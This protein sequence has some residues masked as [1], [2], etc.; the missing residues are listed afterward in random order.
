MSQNTSLTHGSN[1]GKVYYKNNIFYNAAS[2]QYNG[3]AYISYDN[4]LFYGANAAAP[5]DPH[6]VVADPL[7]VNPGGAANRA[8]ADA[9]KL[10]PGSPAIDSGMSINGNGGKD[11][12]GNPLYNGAPDI[13]AIEDQVT[14]PQPVTI[15]SDD[16]EDNDFSNWT[17][18][19]G[20]WSLV[21][22]GSLALSQNTASGEALAFTGDTSWSDY[23][24]S[25][26]VKLLAVTG[27]AGL[28][29]SYVDNSNYYALRLNDSG[30]KVELYK[31]SG[32]TMTLA[33]STS[34]AVTPGR[35]A[36]MKVTVSGNTITGFVDGVQLLQWTDTSALPAG[37]IGIRMHTST[38]RID[39]VKVI[40]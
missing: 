29:F 15:F 35:W 19:G 28:V 16:F 20:S 27:N 7:F 22:D 10:Q 36:E 6:K 2:S 25:A 14:V 8:T 18:S 3:S 37:K 24:Y 4:N 40:Q 32:G 26:R 12:F 30:D 39:D 17:V 13:G 33:S 5:N 31:K 11:F 21:T 9:Y 34:Y 38:A 23:T 1:S